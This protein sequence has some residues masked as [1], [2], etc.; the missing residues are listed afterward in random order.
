MAPSCLEERVRP[1]GQAE[2]HPRRGF[3]PSRRISEGCHRSNLLSN[4][5]FLILAYSPTEQ[6]T[7]EPIH[8]KHLQVFSSPT[9][10]FLETKDNNFLFKSGPFEGK[11]L[12]SLIVNFV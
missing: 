6:T 7:I 10:V 4:Y 11:R 2:V 3:L 8:T 9:L 1:S 5:C 12:K